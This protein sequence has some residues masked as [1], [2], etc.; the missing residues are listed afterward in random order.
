MEDLLRQMSA[1]ARLRALSLLSAIGM[2]AACSVSAPIQPVA[3]NASA[4]EGAGQRISVL[5]IPTDHAAYRVFNQ[6]G[7]AFVSMQSE[8]AQAEQRANAFC[9]QKDKAMETLEET[10]AYA[11]YVW[12]HLPRIEIV[13]DCV[14]FGHIVD[15]TYEKLFDL[16]K[17]F[18]SGA[19][20][21]AQFDRE[22]AK[23]L[24]ER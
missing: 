16:K 17:R 11:P 18:E 4:L 12:G 2:L 14:D 5:P 13:F 21:K 7:C 1:V 8:R 15:D 3:M 24:A 23:I 20:T 22:K 9:G 19:V 10:V 6:A